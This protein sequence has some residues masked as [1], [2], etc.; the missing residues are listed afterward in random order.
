[1]SD[2]KYVGTACGCLPR[3]L[4]A[5]IIALC[6][7]VYGVGSVLHAVLIKHLPG[8]AGP[9]AWQAEDRCEGHRCADVLTCRG[10]REAS[11]HFREVTLLVCCVPFGYWGVLGSLHRHV[12]DLRWFGSSLVGLAILLVLLILGD[13]LY[14]LF[15]GEYPLNVIDEALLWSIPRLPIRE[16]VKLEIQRALVSYPV[17]LMNKL[18]RFNV[19]SFYL[20][21]E[22][23]TALL[24]SYAGS[25]VLLLADLVLRGH[26]GLGSN[27][28][29]RDW[30]ERVML[31]RG[32]RDLLTPKYHAT[33]DV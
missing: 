23:S 30:R 19:F 5:L 2:D 33:E 22:L 7:F 16:G 21:V 28:S 20:L 3:R 6:I 1:M 8:E 9:A 27:H 32:M 14:V 24:F 11:F 4:F 17:G 10:T 15:C 18:A 31:K 13:G 29:I 26:T 12:K 25:Q